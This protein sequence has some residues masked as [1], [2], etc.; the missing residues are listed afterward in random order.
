MDGGGERQVGG[1]DDDAVAAAVA[2]AVSAFVRPPSLLPHLSY[3]GPLL[4]AKWSAIAIPISDDA[5]NNPLSI[6]SRLRHRID[7]SGEFCIF[8]LIAFSLRRRE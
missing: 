4:T 5:S 1:G 3:R 7:R 6:Y 2:N 8:H